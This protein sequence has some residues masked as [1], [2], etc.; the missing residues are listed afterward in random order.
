MGFMMA[1][2]GR[3]LVSMI[4]LTALEGVPVSGGAAIMTR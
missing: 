4:V 3:H 1:F 2:S